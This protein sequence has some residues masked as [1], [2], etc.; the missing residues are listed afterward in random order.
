MLTILPSVLC[1]LPYLDIHSLIMH[2]HRV[3]TQHILLFF[4]SLML[5]IDMSHFWILQDKLFSKPSTTT[6]NLF[7]ILVK[8]LPCCH[9]FLFKKVVQHFQNSTNYTDSITL[10]ELN[11]SSFILRDC[12]RDLT[13]YPFAPKSDSVILDVPASVQ[14]W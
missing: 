1:L 14:Q 9:N 3:L 8:Q 4:E 6:D 7:Y 2:L 5:C 11:I 13:T 12:A 10:T